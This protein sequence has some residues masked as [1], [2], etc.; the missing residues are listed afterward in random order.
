MTLAL[1]PRPTQAEAWRQRFDEPDWAYAYF[2]KWLLDQPRKPAPHADIA[3]TYDWTTRALAYDNHES[4]IGKPRDLIAKSFQPLL[5]VLALEANALLQ[6][7]LEQPSGCNVLKPKEI[8]DLLK[9]MC[10]YKELVASTIDTGVD[11]NLSKATEVELR[12][13]QAAKKVVAKLGT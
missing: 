5:R 12:I 4:V 11:R 7:V 1:V 6:K 3:K 2:A 9:V 13:V 8:T 10:E